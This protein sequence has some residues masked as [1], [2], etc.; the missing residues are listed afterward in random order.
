VRLLLV[1]AF[2]V[3]E[4]A[5]KALHK[6]W[7]TCTPL[8]SF[9]G[10]E[11][12]ISLYFCLFVSQAFSSFIVISRLP[13]DNTMDTPSLQAPKESLSSKMI[14]S[15]RI[16]ADEQEYAKKVEQVSSRWPDEGLPLIIINKLEKVIAERKELESERKEFERRLEVARL[17]GAQQALANLDMQIKLDL[18][19]MGNLQLV[20]GHDF[21]FFMH[22][23]SSNK[24]KRI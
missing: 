13:M 5:Y 15:Q 1:A 7:A 4:K 2:S 19:R 23:H 21:I 8:R 3:T 14:S 11:A 9:P 17:I 20:S 16:L 22:P 12:A 6:L 24:P 18:M 10:P